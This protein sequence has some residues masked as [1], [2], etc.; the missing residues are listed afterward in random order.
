MPLYS[1]LIFRIYAAMN[2]LGGGAITEFAPG[3]WKPQVRHCEDMGCRMSF[4]MHFRHSHLDFFPELL[5]L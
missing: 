5:V 2:R 1:Q 4:K 3:R